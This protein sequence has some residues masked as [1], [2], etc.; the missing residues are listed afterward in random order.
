MRPAQ[1]SKFLSLIG[2]HRFHPP[3]ITPCVEIIPSD[4]TSQETINAASELMR[5]IGKTP[6][7]CKSAPGFVA[8]RIQFAL[9][10]EALARVVPR[11]FMKTR[12]AS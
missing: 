3:H 8:N 9:A 11:I 2:A 5:R 12:R 4:L 1:K 10:A 7:L 6:T